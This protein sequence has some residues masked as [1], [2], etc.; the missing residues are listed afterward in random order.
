[1]ENKKSYYGIIPA[2]VRYDQELPD[3]AKLLYSELTALC[4]E[5]GY[6]WATN[7][8]FAQLYNIHKNSVS[9]LLTSLRNEKHITIIM[10][11]KEN[12]REVKQRRIY[13][14]TPKQNCVEGIN[15]IV[16][17]PINKIVKEKEQVINNTF[18]NTISQFPEEI[19]KKPS[20]CNFDKNSDNID[21][22]NCWSKFSQLQTN[23]LD[24][25]KHHWKKRHNDILKDYTANEVFHAI[26]QY[27]MIKSNDLFWFFYDWSIWDFIG[28][29]LITFLPRATPVQNFV[30]KGVDREQLNIIES[31]WVE[32]HRHIQEEFTRQE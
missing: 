2:N 23:K 27:A 22:F 15:K 6:C 20:K 21:F 24:T 30:I 31:Q 19:N 9:R 32:D 8:Y 1:M 4:N 18:N 28:R 3:K 29:G 7:D 12:S 14:S 13:L 10:V 25:V 17:T 26:D 16:N 11:Y 5:K